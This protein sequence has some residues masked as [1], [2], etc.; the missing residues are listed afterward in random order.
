MPNRIRGD[1]Y[2]DL[3]YQSMV[4]F[5]KEHGHCNVPGGWR[6]REHPNDKE[7]QLA[8]WCFVQTRTWREGKLRPERYEKLTQLGFEWK[9][10][11]TPP[12]L[13]TETPVS[14]GELLL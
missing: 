11:V 2:W 6:D 4:E 5:R 14:Q 10:A 7:R 1:D 3:Q 13:P 8:N 12:S 9:P